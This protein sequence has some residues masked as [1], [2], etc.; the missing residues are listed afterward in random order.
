MREPMQACVL[1]RRADGALP[2]YRPGGFAALAGAVSGG[3]FPVDPA[4]RALWAA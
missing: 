2:P 4:A 3:V 1:A